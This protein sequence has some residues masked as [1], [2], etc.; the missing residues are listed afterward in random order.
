M[1]QTDVYS[2]TVVASGRVETYTGSG[3]FIA[4]A[5]IKAISANPSGAGGVI[6]LYNGTA[7]VAAK[8]KY[9]AKFGSGAGAGNLNVLLPENGILCP[10]GI[11]VDL[12]NC[13]SCTVVWQA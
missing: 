1:G 4:R 8:L 10:D 9:Q 3:A 12:T 13:D 11:Y 6:K 5:R 7:V 2:S